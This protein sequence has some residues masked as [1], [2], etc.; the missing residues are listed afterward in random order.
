MSN[1]ICHE[2][3]AECDCGW[4]DNNPELTPMMRRLILVCA[5]FLTG[6]G[7]AMAYAVNF[8]GAN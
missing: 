7:F 4:P 6:F 1:C 5:L 2:H 8:P 3:K